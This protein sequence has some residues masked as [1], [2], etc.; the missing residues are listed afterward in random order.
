MPRGIAH[1][2]LDIFKD[3]PEFL[4]GEGISR[5]FVGEGIFI[6]FVR[7]GSPRFFGREFRG[8]ATAAAAFVTVSRIPLKPC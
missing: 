3:I 8:A 1:A 2:T 6:F 5:F 7:E 4:A